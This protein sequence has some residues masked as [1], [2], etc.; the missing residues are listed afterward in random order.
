MRDLVFVGY[1]VALL[2]IA[3]KRP[4]LFTLIYAY[5]DIVAPQRLSYFM[6]NSIPL[7]LVVFALA[8]LGYMLADNKQD[9]RFSVRQGMMIL[10]LIYCGYTT[11][12]AEV[13]DAAMEKWDWVW[14]ALVF[15]IFLPLTLRTKLRL[16]ALALFMVLCAGTLIITGGIKT[17]ASGGGY[18]VLVLLV[19]N[20]SGLYEGS[21]I[22]TV[23]ICIIPLILWLANYGTIFPPD[24]RVKIFAYCLIFAALLIPIGT[25]ARTGLVCIGVLAV[26]QLRF[27]RHRLIYGG[28]AMALGLVAIPFLP[29][30]FTERMAT[31]ENY[32]AD[33][34]ASTRLAVWRWTIEYAN[35]H[36]FGGGFDVYRINKLTYE[37]SE[38]D[39]EQY[40][41]W[42]IDPDDV[43]ARLI[44]DESRAFHSSYFEML[45]EQG[46]PGLILWLLIHVGGIW[47]MEML[48]RKY[49]KSEKQG[50]QWVAPLAIA[51]QHGHI[52]FLVGALFVGIAYQPFIYMLV[53]LQIG[54]DTYMSRRSAEA[55]RQ[56]IIKRTTG[57]VKPEPL[58]HPG[59]SFTN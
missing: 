5:V 20:N 14:K 23:A 10:L 53:A 2:F 24:W 40:E 56:P 38:V 16:E 35:Q 31:I 12:Q 18:G 22:S 54:L 8:F 37:L 48:R 26:L 15:A 1:L 43:D 11:I 41:Q 32:E 36:P 52:I 19:D 39:V 13:P 29:Q 45:G 57:A 25:Q 42:G 50:E 47:R 49:A 44:E 30:S 28:L 55:R 17:L 51:L 46:Y 59:R 7:S 33:Q 34:S 27:A 21:I 6:L 9:S 4:F 3:F 58:P